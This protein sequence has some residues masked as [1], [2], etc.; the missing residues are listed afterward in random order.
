MTQPAGRVPAESA[1]LVALD[2]RRLQ[3]LHRVAAHGSFSRAAK[4]LHFTQ[5]AVSQQ[6][7]ALERDLGVQLVNRNPVALTEAG[8]MLCLRYE[9][10][11]AELAAAKAELASFRS[12]GA[13]RIRVSAVG[14]A[15]SRIV[16]GAAA[17][18]EARFPDVLVQVAQTDVAEAL[19]RLQQGEADIALTFGPEPTASPWPAV[20]WVRL[21]EERLCVAVP[22]AHRLARTTGLQARDLQGEPFLYAPGA[23]VPIAA[24][25]EAFGGLAAPTIVPAGENAGALPEMVAAGRGLALVPESDAAAMPGIKWLPLVDPPL[26]RSVYTVTLESERISAAMAAMLDELATSAR[27]PVRVDTRPQTLP[28]R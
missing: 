7:A 4:N 12:G 27:R 20:R 1:D 26:T 22:T 11:V 3:T 16:S 6:V 9:A 24:F 15:L 17:A 23:G 8:R 14:P 18:F 5:S 25:A 10:A 13:A 21:T 28:T 2:M 19:A